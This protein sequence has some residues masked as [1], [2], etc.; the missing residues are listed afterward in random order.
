ML[1]GVADLAAGLLPAIETDI[2][3]VGKNIHG[4]AAGTRPTKVQVEEVDA[5][6][7]ALTG[8]NLR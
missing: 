5:L 2:V 4:K 8:V 6:T 7:A 1:R 3:V